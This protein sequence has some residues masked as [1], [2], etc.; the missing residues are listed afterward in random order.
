MWGSYLPQARS[1]RL[2]AMARLIIALFTLLAHWLDPEL[3]I[4]ALRPVL[5]RVAVVFMIYAIVFA[6]LS[7]RFLMTDRAR[8]IIH[9]ADFLLYSVLIDL[10]QAPVVFFVFWIFCGMLR[11][12]TRG[13][14]A[15]ASIAVAT[16]L[17]LT[18]SQEAVRSEPGYL[19]LRLASL[20]TVALF[21]VSF[22]AHEGR[23]RSELSRI[24]SWPQSRATTRESLVRDTLHS[25]C[26]LLQADLAA[27]YWEES[28]EP[29]VW[30]A[31]SRREHFT[32]SREGPEFASA[33]VSPDAGESTFLCDWSRTATVLKDDG[34]G[35][36]PINNAL[37]PAAAI[38]ARCPLS[39]R[40]PNPTTAIS[41]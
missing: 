35:P 17:L 40:K 12:G 16:Y 9:I 32:M 10:T 33:L 14:I 3:S 34:D 15:T 8:L 36:H 18:I 11:F 5:M 7:T 2:I 6:F 27:I 31:I 19:V 20:I 22:G 26:D 13:A 21:L 1:D 24:A 4:A 29:W 25:A 38:Q 30:F 37:I 41:A 23:V 28:E 39:S